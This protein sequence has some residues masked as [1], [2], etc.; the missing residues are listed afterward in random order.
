[1]SR[2]AR[3]VASIALLVASAAAPA[4]ADPVG[5]CTTNAV[6]LG[7]YGPCVYLQNY[8]LSN[9]SA[10]VGA[11]DVTASSQLAMTFNADAYPPDAQWLLFTVPV[12][13][14]LDADATSSTPLEVA[15]RLT[16]LNG[17]TMSSID[18]ALL[19][20]GLGAYSAGIEFFLTS[21][22]GTTSHRLGAAGEPTRIVGPLAQTTT[23][24]V[25]VRV[26]G[27]SPPPGGHTVG[28]FVA[29]EAPG[30]AEEPAPVPEPA[31]VALFGT[32]LVLLARARRRLPP[33]P[34]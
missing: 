25:L 28:L 15:Y 33:P 20:A 17:S 31:T 13:G 26:F 8:L 19:S 29:G 6:S 5:P 3:L 1:M 30:P 21:D 16:A 34:V 10:R 27:T 4:H 9:I 24:D 12:T 32:G 22:A 11:A 23:L 2:R 18:M 7:T 14:A